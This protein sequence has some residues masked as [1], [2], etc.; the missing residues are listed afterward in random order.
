MGERSTKDSTGIVVEVPDAAPLV[1]DLRRRYDPLVAFGGPPHITVLFPWIQLPEL[2]D[3]TRDA[4]AALA[5]AMP[6]FDAELVRFGRFPGVGYLTPAPTA[7]FVALTRAVQ[8]RWPDY[9]PYRGQFD[10]P[11][12]HLTVAQDQP[13][14]V[15]DA[16]E[17]ELTPGLPIRFAVRHLTVLG[18]DG[19]R[20]N[21]AHRV[22]LG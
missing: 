18:F 11:V 2:D 19:H 8:R 7:P 13:D 22:R 15:L 14:P 3:A 1:A 4:L 9:Q 16:I 17:S 21:R 6:V 12:P 5:G 10:Q 20:W